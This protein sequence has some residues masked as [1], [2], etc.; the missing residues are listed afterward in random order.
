MKSLVASGITAGLIAACSQL[1]DDP[2][3]CVTD[4]ECA[5]FSA[6]C[7]TSQGICVKRST[8]GDASDDGEPPPDRD[9]ATSDSSTS[10]CGVAP[11]PT[12]SIGEG[13][14]GRREINGAV[15]LSCDKDWTLDALVFIRAGATLTI[16]A[17]TTI[18]A[19]P[20]VGGGIV[21]SKGG[22]LI[23]NGERDLPIVITSGAATPAA[24]DWRG[25]YWL[26][27]APPAGAPPYE[28]DPDLPWGGAK[29]DD[30][31]GSLMFARIEYARAGLAF[32]GVGNKTKVDFVE[33][34]HSQTNCFTFQ[35]GTVDSK[36]LICQS[37]GANQFEWYLKHSGRAQFL[38][39]QG[40]ALPPIFN[41]G[42]ALIDDAASTI[43]NATLCGDRAAAALN[44]YGVVF[45]DNATL[46]LDGAI[47][48]GWFGGLDAT[49]D[50]PT[51]GGPRASIFFGNAENPAFAEDPAETDPD[52][53]TFDDDNGLDEIDLIDT[54]DP[55]NVTT[56]PK[57]ADCFDKKT[58]SPW[59]NAA[60]TANAPTPPQD[61][62]FDDA[63]YVGAFKDPTDSWM[64]GSWARFD[65][66]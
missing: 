11:K 52:L 16:E 7:D 48:S 18:K 33:V 21:V 4:K 14:G 17:G 37:P 30:D 22:R 62:F 9:A 58:P 50:L 41:S 8:D 12:E 61:G 24:G 47:I 42:G 53:P 43:F 31:S 23:A 64:R 49:G 25:V 19:K 5:R 63:R 66:R 44:G 32:A 27:D 45:R 3:Q 13:D 57:L 59:P 6:V 55:A 46:H 36:H 34:R 39:G 56:D 2:V 26:G 35:G 1:F 15:T 10:R 38:F 51:P 65:D 20:G 29:S 28:N 60:I 40:A 54:A